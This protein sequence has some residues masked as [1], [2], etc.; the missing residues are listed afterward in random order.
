MSGF[1]VACYGCHDY[2]HKLKID[3]LSPLQDNNAAALFFGQANQSAWTMNGNA[4][5]G[6]ITAAQ[7]AS[8]NG[9][10]VLQCISSPLNQPFY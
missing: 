7:Y 4:R 10:K 2:Q 6:S 1:W 8:G 9:Q 3:Y 5:Q